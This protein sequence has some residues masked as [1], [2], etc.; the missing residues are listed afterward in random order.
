MM[1][2]SCL[3]L[4]LLFTCTLHATAQEVTFN[5]DIAPIIHRNCTPCHRQGEAAPFPL[6]TYDD[7]ARR[8][9]FIREVVESGYMPPWKPDAAY[10]SFAHERK[11]TPEEISL[12]SRWAQS[13]APEGKGSVK[14]PVFVSGTLYHRAPDLTLKTDKPFLVKG[15]NEE[16]FIVFKIPFE[17]ADSMNVEALEFVSN[18]K[19]VVHHANFAIHPVEEGIDIR[20]TAPY[21]DLSGEDR[22]QYDQYLPYKKS[23]TY[24]GGWIPGTTL[25]SYPAGMGWVMPKRGVILLTVHFAPSGKNEESISGVNLFFTKKPIARKVKVISIGSGGVGERDIEPYFM[26]QA[27]SVKTFTVK[28]ATPGDQSLLY[29]W[30]HMHLLGKR[31]KAW[32]TTPQGDTVR[33]VDIPDWD[34]KWQE[35]YRFKNLIKVPK[36]SVLTVEGTYDNTSK[37]PNNPFNPP[38]MIFAD[39]DMKTTQEMMTMLMVFLPYEPGDEQLIID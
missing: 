25:E 22:T 24:Y 19:K 27:D 30:P 23:M 38:R 37:N 39:G 7:V 17:L 33:L 35:I 26:I 20:G 15:D 14:P 9:T 6:V 2:R 11:L 4:M 12:I 31:F 8:A 1:L 16:R 32:A 29:I 3:S 13:K 10:R 21:V 36:G 34:F 5:K 18:N 28:V